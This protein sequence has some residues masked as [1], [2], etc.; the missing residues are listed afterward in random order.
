MFPHDYMQVVDPI[1]GVAAEAI[2]K[3]AGRKVLPFKG[4]GNCL[5][6][7]L[8]Y[9]FYGTEMMHCKRSVILAMFVAKDSNRFEC[10]VM[11]STIEGHI[12]KSRNSLCAEEHK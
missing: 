12:E 7:A 1:S 10:I 6:R 3:V 8:G 5:F 9:Y 2:L 11:D 4:D